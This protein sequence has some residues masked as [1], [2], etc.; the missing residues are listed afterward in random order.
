MK[1]TWDYCGELKN[2][3]NEIWSCE[4][5]F[6]RSDQI[7]IEWLNEEKRTMIKFFD[8]E[9]VKKWFNSHYPRF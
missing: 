3:K 2:A 6:E 8:E 1:H 4:A 7:E 5:G 9:K